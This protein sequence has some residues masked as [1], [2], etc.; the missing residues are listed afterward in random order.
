[1]AGGKKVCVIGGGTSGLAG[2]VQL[3]NE[4]IEV[5]FFRRLSPSALT[6][7]H[8]RRSSAS[9]RRRASAASSTGARTRTAST[10]A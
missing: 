1:M 3:I 2:M 9:R 8:I 4:G 10:T 7:L 6:F 5:R